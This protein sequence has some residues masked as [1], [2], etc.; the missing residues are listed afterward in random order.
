MPTTQT[1]ETTNPPI[2]SNQIITVELPLGG[3]ASAAGAWTC[4]AVGAIVSFDW[5]CG[6]EESPVSISSEQYGQ[7][8]MSQLSLSVWGNRSEASGQKKKPTESVGFLVSRN[9]AGLRSPG[10]SRLVDPWDH[11][12]R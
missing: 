8:T 5:Q 12:P 11:S 7:G 1:P 4:E 9:V 3:A 6:Q 2:T 10:H